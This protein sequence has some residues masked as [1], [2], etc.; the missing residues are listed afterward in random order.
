MR[1]GVCVCMGEGVLVNV[2]KDKIR[3]VCTCQ[4]RE[5]WNGP[6][7]NVQQPKTEGVLHLEPGGKLCHTAE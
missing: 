4:P 3:S 6:I 7:P 1:V 2:S 5:I